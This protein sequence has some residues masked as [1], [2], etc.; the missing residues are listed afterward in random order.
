VVDQFD[1]YARL[2]PFRHRAAD[3]DEALKAIVDAFQGEILSLKASAIALPELQSLDD[4]PC[5]YL[6][7]LANLIGLQTED[8]DPCALIREQIRAA[9]PIYGIKGTTLSF[10][11]LMRTLG[12]QATVIPL[13]EDSP[14]SA[15][16]IDESAA[17]T[18]FNTRLPGWHMSSRI[19]LELE[20]LP[21]AELLSI[22]GFEGGLLTPFLLA[23]LLKK[24]REIT[25]IHIELDMNTVYSFSDVIGVDDAVLIAID[26][27]TRVKM[28]CCCYHGKGARVENYHTVVRYDAGFK[29]DESPPRIYDEPG[30]HSR[31]PEMDYPPFYYD[32]VYSHEC[33]YPDHIY[34]PFRYR[35]SGIYC[36]RDESNAFALQRYGYNK[37]GGAD[38][39][40]STLLDT[41]SAPSAKFVSNMHVIVGDF[42]RINHEYRKVEEVLGETSLRIVAPFSWPDGIYDYEII[43][44]DAY[45]RREATHKDP[46]NFTVPTYY[47]RIELTIYNLFDTGLLFDDGLFFDDGGLKHN[48]C[49]SEKLVSEEDGS[50]VEEVHYP[51]ETIIPGSEG[52]LLKP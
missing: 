45:H 35:L 6:A 39:S 18:G 4:V 36:R 20:R 8:C 32:T 23:R 5:D 31:A 38:M 43:F 44:S 14:D 9:V 7:Y 52:I 34:D 12:F 2:I 16:T 46:L 49:I 41:V 42:V 17:I 51:D 26:Y 13:F 50:G 3:V 15:I 25:P 21:E 47:H 11:A 29:Y 24:L 10:E 28:G 22:C 30:E 33:Q 37:G 48:C 27:L 19:R 1:F 40:I